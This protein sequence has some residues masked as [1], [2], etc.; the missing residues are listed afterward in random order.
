MNPLVSILV[1]V[2]G[3]ARYVEQ[4]AHSLLNQSYENLEI[5]IVNDASPDRSMDILHRVAARYPERGRKIRYIDNE[6]NLKVSTTRNE[7]LALASGKYILQ[8]DSDDWM[9]REMVEKMTRMA[10]ERNADIVW[11]DY[12]QNYE[13]K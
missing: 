6:R 8:V 13:T 4:F 10:E 7:A 5:I 11:C 12:F 3:V 9:E 1:P 2:Y